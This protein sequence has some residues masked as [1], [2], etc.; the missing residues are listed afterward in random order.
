M[1][2]FSFLDKLFRWGSTGCIF[3]GQL[4]KI[5]DGIRKPAVFADHFESP[6]LRTGF[7]E[8]CFRSLSK[9]Y[10]VYIKTRSGIFLQL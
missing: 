8:T 4:D 1:R 9:F 2:Q 3:I 10:L 7:Q 6:H 5:D